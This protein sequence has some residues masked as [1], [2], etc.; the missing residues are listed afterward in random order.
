[1][2]KRYQVITSFG[3][4]RGEYLDQEV[5]P[6]LTTGAGCWHTLI[7]ESMEE[8]TLTTMDE[9]HREVKII[10]PEATKKG[11]DTATYGDSINMAY[12]NSKTRRGRVGHGVAQTL[13]AAGEAQ[14]VVIEP[15]VWDGYNQAI[16]SDSTVSGTIT[17]NVGADL[18]R[19]G[20]GIIEPRIAALRGRNPENP[21]DRTAGSPMEQRLEIGS[22]E[23]SNTLTT[24]QKDNL[25]IEPNYELSAAMKRYIN[26]THDKYKVSDGNLVLNRDIACAKTTREGSTRAD[27]SDYISP[28]FPEN[29]NV[30]GVDLQQYRIRK[31]TERECFRLM[32]VKKEDFE[33]VAENQST[34]SLYHLSGDSIVTACLMAIFGQLFG[35]DYRIKINE[36]VGELKQS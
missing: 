1:M 33:R 14:Q 21:S 23:T 13:T 29:A 27:A 35:V 15:L 6:T 25:V 31:L 32:G 17:R 28:D 19:N 2:G 22:E 4:Y 10:V 12:P 5:C 8:I 16:K 30:A 26:A 9:G 24:V 3:L 36:L 11:Y 18:K 34:S 7:G 20:Q